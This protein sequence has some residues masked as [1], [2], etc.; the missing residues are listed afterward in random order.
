MS[1]YGNILNRLDKYWNKIKVS[2]GSLD[3]P[4]DGNSEL[5]LTSS[6]DLEITKTN[7]NTI[8]FSAGGLSD[9]LKIE[10]EKKEIIDTDGYLT[11]IIKQN[12]IEY[13]INIP[14]DL[15]LK[16]AQVVN[17]TED[18]KSNYG[19]TVPGIYIQL[20][21]RTEENTEQYVYINVAEL[22]EIAGDATDTIT[23]KVEN[24]KITANVNDKSITTAKIADNAITAE[25]L[26]SDIITVE[27][28]TLKILQLGKE[29]T[30]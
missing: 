5:I 23:I 11:Y 12:D 18:N 1:F 22:N 14:L 8:N 4:E 15:I 19:N 30:K 24:Q 29:E 25:K 21:F 2:D 27:N 26:S 28:N 17:I 9:R 16:S 10:V 20:I 7:E 6:A 3:A 13:N